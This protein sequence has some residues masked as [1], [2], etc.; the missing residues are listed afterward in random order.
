M[1]WNIDARH[2]LRTGHLQKSKPFVDSFYSK[3]VKTVICIP[4]RKH[5]ISCEKSSN[6]N[7]LY[8]NRDSMLSGS[9]KPQPTKL[10]KASFRRRH[11]N[12][13]LT[14]VNLTLVGMF[15]LLSLFLE[16]NRRLKTEF[17]LHVH[18]RELSLLFM[19]G[20]PIKFQTTYG[21]HDTS[22]R[23]CFA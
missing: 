6:C 15:T 1:L 19:V 7:S 4:Q 21:Y 20:E 14:F 10:N 18:D 8:A 16:W 5:F 2:Y 17:F 9:S 12:L 11:H 23:R 13:P 3:K 22:C